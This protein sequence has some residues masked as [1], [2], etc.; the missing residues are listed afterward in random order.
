MAAVRP[1]LDTDAETRGTTVV[2]RVRGEIDLS[3][4]AHF[5]AALAVVE[6]AERVEIDMSG[7]TFMGSCGIE[8]LVAAHET[9]A[10]SGCA[11]V[12]TGVPRIVRRVLEIAG[13]DTLFPPRDGIDVG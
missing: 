13:L 11:L 6:S 3:T 10:K 9:A 5:T 12:L 2:L 1:L 8:R 4:A 7:V